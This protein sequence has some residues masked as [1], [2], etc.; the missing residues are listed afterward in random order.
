MNREKL[1]KICNE[2]SWEYAT[3]YFDNNLLVEKKEL[4]KKCINMGTRIALE[5]ASI[6]VRG[7]FDEDT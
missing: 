3:G 1:V 7:V 2:K 4:I 5:Q 6:N